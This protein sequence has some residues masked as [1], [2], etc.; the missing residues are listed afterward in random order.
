MSEGADR[1]RGAGSP[2]LPGPLWG[3]PKPLAPRSRRRRSRA[4]R[5]AY[6]VAA[7]LLAGLARGL[8]ATY[9]V[10]VASGERGTVADGSRPVILSFW[11]DRVLV[12]T[13]FVQLA[14]RP[15]L[16]P[17][18][19]VSPSVDGDLVTLAL[20]RLGGRVVRGSA[21]RSGVKS[22]RDLWRAMRREGLSPVIVPDGPLGPPHRAKPGAVM[23]AQLAGAPIVPIA[24][25]VRGA[26]RL[27]TWDRLVVP[28][29]FARVEVR[30]G[31]AL[32]VGEGDGELERACAELERRLGG[33]R[34]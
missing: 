10:R 31:E 1:S 15:P 27:P 28:L 14:W 9:R 34:G 20:E 25:S 4:R 5:L 8:W 12:A 6:R 17:T 29:P 18:Y 22:L 11:H 21:T 32:E 2:E 24:V 30:L 19:L 33:E 7:P 23:L 3:G 13:G 26:V 16:A